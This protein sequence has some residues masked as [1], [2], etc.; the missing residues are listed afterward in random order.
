[1]SLTAI[2]DN[3]KTK[4]NLLSPKNNTDYEYYYC[5]KCLKI[6][7]IKFEEGYVL[8]ECNCGTKQDT[9]IQKP[10]EDITKPEILNQF[11]QHKTYKFLLKSYN[12]LNSKLAA[13][14][15][16]CEF[17][18]NHPTE[19]RI[20]N[21]VCIN[22]KNKPFICK[23][24]LQLH[25]MIGE[26]HIK[27]K[28]NGLKISRLCE[29]NGCKNKGEI[30]FYCITCK[31]NLCIY[32]QSNIHNK[33]S[34]IQLN[35]FYSVKEIN[36]KMKLS[37]NSYLKE[38]ESF[39][40][41]LE[42]FVNQFKSILKEEKEKEKDI[43]TFIKSLFNTYQCTKEVLNYNIINNIKIN[44]IDDILQQSSIQFKTKLKSNLINI[45]NENN[46][47]SIYDNLNSSINQIPSEKQLNSNI[48]NI[49]NNITLINKEINQ[50]K[51]NQSKNYNSLIINSNKIYSEI[52]NLI[53]EN[54]K[55]IKTENINLINELKIITEKKK[56]TKV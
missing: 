36:S 3:F 15:R 50:I 38:I 21:E 54:M 14:K 48:T 42:L 2:T 22:C 11:S 37:S 27:I 46:F 40:N 33:H 29:Q 26:D 5:P 56:E 30:N 44:E 13:T 28:S 17:K 45:L 8:I 47:M 52:E 43:Q 12:L 39:L 31:L 23:S 19:E 9:K 20:A 53:A 6:P 18:K 1:M 41:K 34:V 24:C 55:N 49:S 32:C 51:E 25:D 7:K 4:E 10:E 35:S 16:Y